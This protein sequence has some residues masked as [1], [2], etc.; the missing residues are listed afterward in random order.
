[1][2]TWTF[3]LTNERDPI[4]RLG[5][6]GLWRCLFY[7]EDSA[8][9]PR[10]KQSESLSWELTDTSVTVHWQSVD[11]LNRLIHGM[12]GDFRQGIAIIPG[13]STDPSVPYFYATA[14]AHLCI[15]AKFFFTRSKGGTRSKSVAGTAKAA[16]EIRGAWAA[17]T[18][19]TIIEMVDCDSYPAREGQDPRP[20]EMVVSPHKLPEKPGPSLRTTAK[21]VLKAQQ[22][23]LTIAHP[24]LSAWRN[25]AVLVPPETFFLLSFACLAYVYSLCNDG[26]A[27]LGIDRPTFSDADRHVRIWNGSTE[28][29][30]AYT[31]LDS[32]C[33]VLFWTLAAAL[34]LP[35]GTY[36][37]LSEVRGPGLFSHTSTGHPMAR[38][39][40]ALN[41]LTDVRGTS[42]FLRRLRT[43]PVRVDHEGKTIQSYHKSLIRSLRS[44]GSW[45]RDL[46]RAVCARPPNPVMISQIVQLL[47]SPME[48]EITR[49][50]SSLYWG[51]IQTLR[52]KHGRDRKVYKI[53]HDKLRMTLGRACTAGGILSGI[54][55]LTNY[56]H[57][58]SKLTQEHL[59]WI[60]ENAKRDPL[61]VKEL[62]LVGCTTRDEQAI[63]NARANNTPE[64][65]D[66]DNMEPLA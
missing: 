20:I 59:D 5:L 54:R 56:T 16:R 46:G 2:N 9:H 65:L 49:A 62:L 8:C 6:H 57:G 10:I 21:G 55:A 39:H 41:T 44:G 58:Y 7:G 42:T 36:P 24:T 34:G 40:E 25:H 3:D 43:L 15:C 52:T 64:D 31:M 50:M 1:M 33:D 37:T 53:A 63:A 47:G 18:G 66:L 35:E 14:R 26:A 48:Q 38:I 22:K 28:K 4:A 30:V 11:D 32:D 23:G 61:Y 60:V 45:T 17:H 27:G 51:V 13:Y 29:A 19:H 12:L